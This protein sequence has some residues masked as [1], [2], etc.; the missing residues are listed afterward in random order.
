MRK[1]TNNSPNHQTFRHL[2]AVGFPYKTQSKLCLFFIG[3]KNFVSALKGNQNAAF[4]Q[5]VQ[6]SEG[7][8]AFFANTGKFW[9]ALFAEYFRE[10]LSDVLTVQL[11]GENGAVRAE[12]FVAS[13]EE[14]GRD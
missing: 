5:W 12:V 13:G 10:Y 1:D 7:D 9:G 6:P 14:V 8:T 4:C 3:K 11:S 2:F